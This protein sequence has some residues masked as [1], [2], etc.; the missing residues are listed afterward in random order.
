MLS[1]GMENR[2]IS[3]S[4]PGIGPVAPGLLLPIFTMASALGHK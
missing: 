3:L 2:R 1:A 4:S